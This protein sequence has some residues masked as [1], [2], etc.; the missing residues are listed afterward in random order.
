MGSKLS[1]LEIEGHPLTS[2]FGA[3]NIFSLEKL[4]GGLR[5]AVTLFGANSL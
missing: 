1:R 2:P 4:C 3:Q 5:P